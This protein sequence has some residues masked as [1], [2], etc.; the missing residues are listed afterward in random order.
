MAEAVPPLGEILRARDRERR[1]GHPLLRKGY[2]YVER[3]NA[4]LP[5]VIPAGARVL[6][7]G[8]GG[9]V[10][11]AALVRAGCSGV[12]VEIDAGAASRARARGLTVY[13]GDVRDASFR[14]RI[15][16]EQGRFDV[17]VLADLLEH[18]ERPEEV[19][20]A[21]AALL[22]PGGKVVVSIPNVAVWFQRLALLF[23]RW[24]YDETGILDRTHLRF[25][26]K[27]SF[28]WWLRS[29]GFRPVRWDVTPSF[30]ASIG[31]FFRPLARERS[32]EMEEAFGG[33]FRFYLRWIEPVEHAVCALWPGLLAFQHV[34]VIDPPDVA[35]P[36]GAA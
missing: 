13:T 34:V 16:L 10:N 30:V 36:E 22:V 28:R 7:V 6:D 3:P 5:R 17:V 11:L 4:T 12:G 2:A 35:P 8:C 9:G 18:L 25:F 33:A 29:L 1:R 31:P 27:S 19:F 32:G 15:A 23:G 26:T 20:L 21:T 14:E 24:N